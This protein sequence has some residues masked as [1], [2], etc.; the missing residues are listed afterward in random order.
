MIRTLCFPLCACTTRVCLCI[1]LF[2]LLTCATILSACRHPRLY[3]IHCTYLASVSRLWYFAV[4]ALYPWNRRLG[5][6]YHLLS[7]GASVSRHIP[8]ACAGTVSHSSHMSNKLTH[9]RATRFYKTSSSISSRSHKI[10]RHINSAYEA[11]PLF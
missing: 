6:Q 9:I 7:R 11:K 3:T 8:S 5:I 4:G 1:A 2:L 10:L